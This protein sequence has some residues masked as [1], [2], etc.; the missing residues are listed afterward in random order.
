MSIKCQYATNFSCVPC[1][2]PKDVEARAQDLQTQGGS[3][4]A[5]IEA[6]RM[7]LEESRRVLSDLQV[8]D[9]HPILETSGPLAEPA[10]FALSRPFIAEKSIGWG[11][12]SCARSFVSVGVFRSTPCEISCTIRQHTSN[13]RRLWRERRQPG[14]GRMA[15]SSI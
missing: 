12:G 11:P 13:E 7:E 4:T 10:P 14:R 2:G 3:S 8:S 5:A 9:L 6:L 1:V 15:Y